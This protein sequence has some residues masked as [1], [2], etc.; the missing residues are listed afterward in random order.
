MKT[1]KY[2]RD[3]I[4]KYQAKFDRININ[5]EKGL[6]ER[7]RAISSESMNAFV[8]RAVKEE[9]ERLE[10]SDKLEKPDNTTSGYYDGLDSDLPFA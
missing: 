3:A 9:I 10:A 7:F 6:K 2:T 5:L 1:P 8:N 4:A